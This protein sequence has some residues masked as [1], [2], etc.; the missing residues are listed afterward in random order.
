MAVGEQG[1]SNHIIE[2]PIAGQGI[3]SALDRSQE[4]RKTIFLPLGHA[5]TQW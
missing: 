1:K 4:V 5:H 3:G 2:S